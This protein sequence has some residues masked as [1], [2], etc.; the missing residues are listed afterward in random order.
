MED[1]LKIISRKFD[2]SKEARQMDDIAA[3]VKNG[4][5]EIK[6]RTDEIIALM[7]RHG[8][9]R[10]GF[11]RSARAARSP[12]TSLPK[13]EYAVGPDRIRNAFMGAICQVTVL[14]FLQSV[15]CLRFWSSYRL[16]T[17][18]LPLQDKKKSTGLAV[19]FFSPINNNKSLFKTSPGHI[20]SYVTRDSGRSQRR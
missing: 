19:L 10:S 15:Q 2:A 18:M 8:G 7:G 20:W 6:L 9:I 3:S 4:L 1:D 13:L 14:N 12:R 16:W 11:P 5:S 17:S